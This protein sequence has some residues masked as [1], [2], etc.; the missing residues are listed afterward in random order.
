MPFSGK[1]AAILPICCIVMAGMVSI[2][3]GTPSAGA[4]VGLRA[5][6]SFPSMT[7]QQLWYL[8]HKVLAEG[9][10]CLRSDRARRAF[11]NAPRCISPDER[12]LSE[13]EQDY[14]KQLRK[15]LKRKKCAH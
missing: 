12:I 3:H 5:P 13:N 4:E 9:R 10:V 11:R 2:F 7:C 14:L 1:P 15:V 6:S 8:E